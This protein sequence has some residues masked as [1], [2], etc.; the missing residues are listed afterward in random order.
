MK[1]LV[2]MLFVLALAPVALSAQ[3]RQRKEAEGQFDN[4]T[5]DF[6]VAR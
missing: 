6:P 5:V 4:A 3:D 1:K 2:L